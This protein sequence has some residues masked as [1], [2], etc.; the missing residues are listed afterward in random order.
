LIFVCSRFGA[1]TAHENIDE[2]QHSLLP[3]ALV[4]RVAHASQRSDQIL[5]AYVGADFTCRDCSFQ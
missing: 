3:T 5:G 1:S 4:V 2:P